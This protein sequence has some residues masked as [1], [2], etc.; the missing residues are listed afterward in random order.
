MTTPFVCESNVPVIRKCTV[1][2]R[3]PKTKQVNQSESVVQGL[4]RTW[5]LTDHVQVREHAALPS[6]KLQQCHRRQNKPRSLRLEALAD[7]LGESKSAAPTGFSCVT[8]HP[9]PGLTDCH[10]VS[11]FSACMRHA[12]VIAS[13]SSSSSSS[14]TVCEGGAVSRVRRAF[15]RPEA[16]C[17]PTKI[18]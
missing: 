7:R 17:S 2:P 6:K 11:W 16:R 4:Q 5:I 13:S 9:N 3:L 8:L 10:A 1:V 14:R 12:C 18:V 15:G